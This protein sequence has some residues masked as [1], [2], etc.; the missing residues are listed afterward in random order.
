MFFLSP[1]IYAAPLLDMK[2][3]LEKCRNF[4]HLHV[5][6]DDGNFVRGISFGIDYIA[7]VAKETDV[8]LDV[9]LEVMNPMD[10]IKPLAEIG[11][12]SIVAHYEVLPYPLLF[13]S[14]VHNLGIKTGL[15]INMRT[16]VSAI[17]PYA[18]MIDELIVITCE[19]DDDGV[20][21]RPGA[22]YKVEEAKKILRDDALLLVDG[23]INAK[24]LED[25]VKLGANGAVMGRAVF[26]AEDPSKA[27]AD[28][29]ALGEEFMKKYQ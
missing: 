17:R 15:A 5:D 29:M 28:I 7:E 6:I 3:V 8:P 9:H 20:I 13:L 19:A 22:L 2:N 4:D 18:D 16:P 25:A 26:K 12:Y 24:N 23:G 21:Y 1:S 11:V 10:Y 27:Y 14:T